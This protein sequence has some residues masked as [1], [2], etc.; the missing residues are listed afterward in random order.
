M[1][2]MILAAGLG[3]RMR[4][5]TD[6]VPKPLLM[7]AGNP[8]IVHSILRCKEAG[9]TDI[10][11]NLCYRGDQIKHMLKDGREWGVHIQYSEEEIP[12][13]MAGGIIHAL[14][15]L[16]N[17][18]FI[19]ISSDVFTDYRFHAWVKKAPHIT[20]AHILMVNHPPYHL[21]HLD[22][23]D[24]IRLNG[25]PK[26]D[27]GGC[28]IFN[29]N[30]FKGFP[31]GSRGISEVL[32]PHILAGKVTGEYFDGEWHNLSTPAQYAALCQQMAA[33]S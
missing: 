29:P 18:P 27:Y 1:K 19:V 2:A 10:V 16:G 11:I 5:L 17:E 4:P 20:H 28:G 33:S 12:L 7:L 21:Y 9:I 22:E 25:E 13:G 24:V 14:P 3:E 15:L 26:W 8:L 32:K 30:I 23:N 6:T 31:A